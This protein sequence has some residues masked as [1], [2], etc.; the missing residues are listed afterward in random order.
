MV[1]PSFV[2]GKSH[3]HS[4]KYGIQTPATWML[5]DRLFPPLT[6]NPVRN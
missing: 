4:R 5:K 1:L 3:R 6:P 2:V